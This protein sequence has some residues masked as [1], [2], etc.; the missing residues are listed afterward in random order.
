[1][2]EELEQKTQGWELAKVEGSAIYLA[3]SLHGVPQVLMHNL[4]HNRVLHQQIIVLTMVTKDEPYVDEAD[5]IKLRV[6]GDGRNFFRVK[7]YFGFMDQPDLRR[8]LHL[9][10]NEGVIINEK[11]TSFLVGSEKISF[12]RKSPFP[13]WRQALFSF[14]VHNAANAIDYY[15]LPVDQVIEIGVRIEL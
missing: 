11:Q 8:S 4:E 12:R 6:F 7:L 3:K 5:R 1:M 9:C 10:K 2:F 15:K 13:A 14:L